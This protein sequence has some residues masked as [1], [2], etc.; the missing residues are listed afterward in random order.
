MRDIY[1]ASPR[2][3]AAERIRCIAVRDVTRLER[4]NARAVS[5][6]CLRQSFMRA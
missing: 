6:L 1:R 4:N 3:F 5:F 2:R